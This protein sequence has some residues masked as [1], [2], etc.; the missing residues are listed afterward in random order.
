[1]ELHN[2]THTNPREVFTELKTSD[3]GLTSKEAI[4]RQK[5]Y[6]FNEIIV[7]EHKIWDVLVRQFKSPFFYLLFIAAIASLFIGEKIDSIVI[8]IFVSTNIVIGFFQ[9]F[10]AERSIMLL[11]KLIPQK[12]K[13]LRDTKKQ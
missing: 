4:L 9:E 2:F 11:K 7:R 10:K 13:V 1:M 6:G 8:L 12:V 5:K 3:T